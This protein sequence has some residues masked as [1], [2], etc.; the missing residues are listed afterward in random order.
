MNYA[1]TIPHGT[2]PDRDDDDGWVPPENWEP[3]PYVQMDE[4]SQ[5]VATPQEL[6]ERRSR[7]NC[8]HSRD[9]SQ[10]R[11]DNRD[12]RDNRSR[13]GSSPAARNEA[14]IRKTHEASATQGRSSN[15]QFADKIW[16]EAGPIAET[17][18]Q[19]Y[20]AKRGVALN[21]EH[22]N[23]R[24]SRLKAEGS[25]HPALVARV[26]GVDGTL[27]GISRTFVKPD[28][29]AKAE[30]DAPR[31]SL[32]SIAGG[33]V[34]LSEVVGE[35]LVL[36]EGIEDGL[37]LFKATS[38]A[39]WA[40]L[41]TSNLAKVKVPTRVHRLIIARDND[42]MGIEAAQNA[43]RDFFLRGFSVMIIA[44]PPTCKDFNEALL[45]KD[46]VNTQRKGD[47]S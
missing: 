46:E 36:C 7:T 16:E 42:P 31:M 35:E 26:Q 22:A 20:L 12:I 47:D 23:L 3:V 25:Y 32:G 28:G 21:R 38:R 10:E 2:R 33:A 27:Q 41:G 17:P 13:P 6:G 39:V 14:S 15:Q 9:R 4:V 1:R 43:A 24:F 40:T 34:R 44:P 18:A 19:V 37:A 29:S 11:R 45:M 8:A 5:A 30:I